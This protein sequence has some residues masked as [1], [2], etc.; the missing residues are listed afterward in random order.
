VQVEVEI[1]ILRPS[2]S[3]GVRMTSCG[4]ESRG[5]AVL[6]PYS[7]CGPLHLRGGILLSVRGFRRELIFG[8]A[9][10]VGGIHGK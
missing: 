6:R 8:L 5:A 9:D 4:F 2:L 3:D 7:E 1:E 10:F